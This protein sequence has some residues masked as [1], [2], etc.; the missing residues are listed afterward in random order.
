MAASCE[1]RAATRCVLPCCPFCP[2]STASS[3]HVT[4]RPCLTA[5]L[6]HSCLPLFPSRKHGHA[7]RCKGAAPY[8]HSISLQHS[9]HTVC[10]QFPSTPYED[11]GQMPKSIPHV[12]EVGTTSA[13]LKSASFFIGAYCKDYNGPFVLRL[14]DS[15]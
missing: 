5:P 1:R 9:A 13:P 12:D 11:P 10:C 2:Q 14:A 15:D 6:R 3:S 8:T 7:Q 4:A